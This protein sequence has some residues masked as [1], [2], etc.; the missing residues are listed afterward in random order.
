M[1]VREAVEHTIL[2]SIGAASLTRERVEAIVSDFVSRGHLGTEEGR[3]IVDRVMSRVRG[4]GTAG[5]SVVERLE[6]G[7]QSFLKEAGVARRE[8]LAELEMR[9]A[10][11]EHRIGLLERGSELPPEETEPLA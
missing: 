11:L 6:G 4:E 3:A 7:V 2:L 1:N 8:E 5:P 10:A 9:V